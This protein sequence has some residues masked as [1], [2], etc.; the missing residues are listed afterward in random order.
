MECLLKVWFKVCFQR[1][2]S[3]QRGRRRSSEVRMTW[4]INRG[5]SEQGKHLITEGSLYTKEG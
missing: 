5:G 3:S 1:E 2:L 4:A